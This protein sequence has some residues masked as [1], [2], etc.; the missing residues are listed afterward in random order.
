ML[1]ALSSAAQ[2]DKNTP[3]KPPAVMVQKIFVLKYADPEQVYPFLSM[4]GGSFHASR[5]MHAI[6]VKADQREMT[7]IEEAIKQLDVPSAAPQNIELTVNLIVGSE[8]ESGTGGAVPKELESVVAQLKGAFPFKNYRQVDQFELRT[9]TGERAETRSEGAVVSKDSLPGCVV[10]KDGAKPRATTITTSFAIRA[11]SLAQ[12][13]SSVRLDSMEASIDWPGIAYSLKLNASVDV[14][15][16]Q[17]VVVGRIG[18][19]HDQALFVVLTAH[20]V[21]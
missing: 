13:G 1:A 21:P 6:A 20:L 4:L 19:A 10:D 8:A 15:E 16:G 17:K 14:K 7:V 2:D 3:P 9:R 18:V 12:D 5:A 11:A